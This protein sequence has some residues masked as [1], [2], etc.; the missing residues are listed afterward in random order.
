[1]A[2]ID[3]LST[4]S[5]GENPKAGDLVATLKVTGGATGETFHFQLADY[6]SGR[7]VIEGNELRVKTPGLF[8]F[9]SS[10]TSFN[11]AISATS[12]G[13]STQVDAASVTV[14][15]TNVNE[16]PTD[17]TLGGLW[18]RRSLKMLHRAL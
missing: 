15:V 4:I 5:I 13:G 12:E 14:K 18:R 3:I 7:F 11:L 2:T 9:E 10:L 17:L 8:D 16:A 1:M 6:F